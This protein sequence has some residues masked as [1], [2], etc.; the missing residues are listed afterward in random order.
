VT[1]L[2]PSGERRPVVYADGITPV[3]P[4]DR[5]SVRWLFRRRSGEVIYVPGI[6]KRRGTYEHNGLTWVGVSLP[7]GWAIGEIVLPDTGRLKASVR[8]LGRGTESVAAADAMERLDA[9]E[10]EEAR[11]DAA[12]EQSSTASVEIPKPREWL[13]GCVAMALQLGLYLLI[14]VLI[15]AG[16][17]LL[18][19]AL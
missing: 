3:L 10:E 8:F 17:R 13:A 9:Q 5:V 19:R 11:S 12:R 7:Q 2:R 4:G 16:L 15:L 1:P 18:W 6:S 14:I